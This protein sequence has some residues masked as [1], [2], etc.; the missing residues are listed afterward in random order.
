MIERTKNSPLRRVGLLILAVGP[1]IFCIGYTIGT[2]SV[3]SMAKAGSQFGMQLLWVLF[4]SCLFS[5][6]LMEAYGR[7]AVVTG[8]TAIHSFRTRLK[9]G[10]AI[11]IVTVT[12]VVIGQ[13]T[14]LS[15]LVNLCANAIYEGV[16]ILVTGL[17][18][19]SYWAVLGIAIVILGSIHALLM[20]GRYSFFERILIVFVGI[21]SVSFVI[22]MFI[23]LPSP[24]EVIAGFVP[25]VPDAP[26]ANMMVAA[27]VGT[28]MAAPTFV[29]RPLLMQGKGWHRDNQKEQS[30]D[31]FV[32]A[33]FMFLISGSI[34][35]AATG[36][37]YHEGKAIG[38]V[39]D[40]VHILQPV[41]GNFAV[42][43]F[44]FGVIS[45]GLSSIFPIAMVCPLLIADY[46]DG[47]LDTNSRQFR[48][49]AGLACVAGLTVSIFGSNPIAA[50]IATQ[51]AQVFVLPVVIVGIAYL[52]NEKQTMGQ[53]K[54]G[55]LLN[56]GLAASLFFALLISYKGVLALAD[57]FTTG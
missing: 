37:M 34:M 13:W 39:L 25:R 43:L 7:Y 41:A 23:V 19:S 4:L 36:A 6:V 22:S 32:S 15:G 9:F 47:K 49:L 18:E 52:V 33:L 40:M 46:R 48:I 56:L 8:A 10:P 20:V 35:V 24:S 42:V 17:P 21:M 14:A 50:Q 16:R 12:G 45:A 28:T 31:A 53:Y 1:G 30:R 26:G 38:K 44:L 2:G 51:V 5:W 29:V 11:A 27:F 3:T 54:A 57:F 55:I